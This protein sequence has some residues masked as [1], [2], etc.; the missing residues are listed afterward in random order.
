MKRMGGTAFLLSMGLL[1][2]CGPAADGSGGTEEGSS[3]AAPMEAT[4]A[5]DVFWNSATIYFLL[6]DRF[7]NGDPTN[8]GAGRP[9]DA[10]L[11][12]GF[13]GGDLA[14]VLDMLRAGYFD[15]L[16]VSALWMTPFTEQIRGGVD[17]GTGRSYGYHGYWA[18]DWTAVEPSL[19]TA[20][21]LRAVVDEAHARGIRVIM[22][23]VIN[24]PGAGTDL[25]EPWPS[26]WIRLEPPCTYR[27]YETTVTCNL[28]PELPDFLT[29]STDAVELPGF[30]VEKWSAEGRLDQ[31]QAELDAFF[32]RTGYP[33]APRYYVMK[34]LTDWVREYG[35]DGY[36]VDTA[37]HFEE[38]VSAELAVEARQAFDDWKAAHPDQVLDDRPFWMMAEV[39][40][41]EL[42]HGRDFSFGDRTVDFYDFGY[43]ALI[44]FGFK[45]RAGGDLDAM[46][47]D[48]AAALRT[49]A[50][51]GLSTVNYASSH[52]DGGP[53][54]REREQPYR[55]GTALLL[56]P[57]AAQIYYGDELARPLVV[58]GAEGDANLRSFMNWEALDAAGGAALLEHWRALG[59]FRAA[60]PA[61]GAGAHR[62]LQTEPYVFAR[63]L[64]QDGATDR[65]VVGLDLPEGDKTLPVGDV[66]ADGE[67]VVDAYTG[68][69]ATVEG[70]AVTL[71]TPA[72]VVLLE[73]RSAEEG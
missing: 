6:T 22:D 52:D 25:D 11:L 35:F 4:A 64:D 58:D 12:R 38:Q 29:E 39:Y 27:D 70:G 28:V 8:D 9:D 2:G 62:R 19:G 1:V 65:V 30:L 41:Y 72:G 68:T 60:H 43:D 18:K 36:R 61:V 23:A 21:D 34:W 48:Y 7:R 16:G 66:F 45:G 26:D 3:A 44:N 10:A 17:E 73:I 24:H 67:A 14:G 40:N 47:T 33:R 37:K 15:E 31:E 13:E 54:D 57:G 59:R 51:Q 32:E 55:T 5:P 42:R 50:L 56:A 20:D 46:Y 69:A 71:S 49:G 53:L 63:T